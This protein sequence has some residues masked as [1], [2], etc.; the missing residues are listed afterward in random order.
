[1]ALTADEKQLIR[2]MLKYYSGEVP[3]LPENKAMIEALIESS[4]ANK[5]ALI[6]TYLKN[7]AIP[8]MQTHLIQIQNTAIDVQSKIVSLQDYSKEVTP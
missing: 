3:G 4:E 8:Q 6:K 7:I 1:M 2:Q 5:I